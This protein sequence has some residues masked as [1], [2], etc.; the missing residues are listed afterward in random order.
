[1]YNPECQSKN[2]TWT[3]ICAYNGQTFDGKKSWSFYNINSNYNNLESA[4]GFYI[5]NGGTL[6]RINFNRNNEPYLS[7]TVDPDDL[8][9]SKYDYLLQSYGTIVLEGKTRRAIRVQREGCEDHDYWVEGIGALRGEMEEK[10][11]SW[12]GVY[13]P[14]Y[15]ELLECYEGFE[16][17]YDINHFS[18][19]LYTPEHTYFPAL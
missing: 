5:E 15:V 19:D 9:M 10:P 16:K 6:Y 2:K 1:M 13:E 11:L 14:L 3:E 17:I 4:R 8:R 12:P 7:F 18:D